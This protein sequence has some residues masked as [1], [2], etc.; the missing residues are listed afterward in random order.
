MIERPRAVT[1]RFLNEAGTV[2]ER[3]FVGLWATS[4]QHQI[5]H[6]DGRM[7]HR[8]P[9]APESQDAGGE[10]RKAAG[11]GMKIIFMGTPDF[12]VPAL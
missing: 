3:D 10:G 2:D 9:L 4:V 8:P 7:Y 6:L 1:V 11:A 12:S 5:D